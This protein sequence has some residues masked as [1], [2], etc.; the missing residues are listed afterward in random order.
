[1]LINNGIKKFK[2]KNIESIFNR[3]KLDIIYSINYDGEQKNFP[4]SKL[5]ETLLLVL[6]EYL[7][8]RKG[9]NF[10]QLLEKFLPFDPKFTYIINRE[11]FKKI[12]KDLEVLEL[13]T[14]EVNL[15]FS[16][17]DQTNRGKINY[18]EFLFELR[19]KMPDTRLRKVL[20]IYKQ[21]DKDQKGYINVKDINRVTNNSFKFHDFLQYSLPNNPII[22]QAK[23]FEPSILSYCKNLK[24]SSDEDVLSEEEFLDFHMSTNLIMDRDRDFNDFVDNYWNIV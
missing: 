20:S 18:L 1:M 7:L 21:I 17:Y 6:K 5:G 4:N 14:N 19:G 2:F 23:F 9:I 22:A 8:K 13:N 16:R 10:I 12:M 15:L 24:K 11:D 3:K